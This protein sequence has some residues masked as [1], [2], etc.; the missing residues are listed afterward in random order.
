MAIVAQRDLSLLNMT[1]AVL[2]R[3]QA[4]PK[5]RVSQI[6]LPQEQSNPGASMPESESY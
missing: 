4:I 5:P 3:G 6:L 1:Q 2:S